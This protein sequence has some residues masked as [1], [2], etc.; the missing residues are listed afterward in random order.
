MG[1]PELRRPINVGGYTAA[2]WFQ[3]EKG[4]WGQPWPLSLKE[5]EFLF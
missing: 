4:G 2:L 3:E 1:T 5:L